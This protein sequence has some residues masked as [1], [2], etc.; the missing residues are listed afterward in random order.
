MSRT[1]RRRSCTLGVLAGLGLALA[2]GAQT[3]IDGPARA[4]VTAEVLDSTPERVTF[5]L[6][7]GSDHAAR[8]V[9]VLISHAFHWTNEFAPGRENPSRAA[10]YL[11]PGELAPRESREAS[12]TLTPPLPARNDGRFEVRVE[13]LR[14]TDVLPP[15]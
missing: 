12:Y 10:T 14:W 5:R 2:A 8:D 7:N 13:V 3:V 4:P 6:T 9:E 11:V 1:K 15:S